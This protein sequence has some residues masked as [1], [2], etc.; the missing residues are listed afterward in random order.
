MFGG[1]FYS[2]SYA[3]RFL[4]K[5]QQRFP[6]DELDG[7][8][9]AAIKLL[10]D[11]QNEHPTF[12]KQMPSG[13]WRYGPG[14]KDMDATITSCATLALLA[15]KQAGYEVPNET[16]ERATNY[17]KQMQAQ[18]GSFYYAGRV[19]FSK[20]SV[21]RSAAVMDVLLRTDTID[22]EA[23]R[24]GMKYLKE[25]APPETDYFF[26]AHYYLSETLVF[27]P[28]EFA[29]WYDKAKTELL[30]RQQGDG[31]WN[32]PYGSEYATAKACIVLLSPVRENQKFAAADTGEPSL[33]VRVV[34]KAGKPIRNAEV[35]LYDEQKLNS[36]GEARFKNVLK[37][38]N[39][40]GEC[41][42][43]E[44]PLH[45]VAILVRGRKGK[46]DESSVH[47][48]T[49]DPRP[50]I[51]PNRLV[52]LEKDRNEI[53]VT[54]TMRQGV[55][56]QF[57]VVDAVTKRPIHF[58][59]IHWKDVKA[60]RWWQIGLLDSG[61]QHNATTLVPEMGSSVFRAARAGY[62]PVDFGFGGPLAVGVSTNRRI[63]LKPHPKVKL[64][65]VTPNGR[66]AVNAKIRWSNLHGLVNEETL[67]TTA[68]ANGTLEVRYPP[69]P[70]AAQLAVTHESGSLEIAFS[71]I[72][73]DGIL[74]LASADG[75]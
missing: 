31:D 64:S 23:R 27:D 50:R 47:L 35:L 57:E 52:R 15:A 14:L 62:V 11:S 9:N 8:I 73:D 54:H 10:A 37:R 56:L 26:Y 41:D 22:D 5:V 16:L 39:E 18:D 12:S 71:E 51:S 1:E 42:F 6:N 3:L 4:A 75:A 24:L 29:A 21:A 25:T 70:D 63:E 46:F 28:P 32:S 44:L 68:N 30:K 74:T 61:G 36:G 69:H 34:D 20:N 48:F 7:V 60:N 2:H 58:A 59:G 55:D 53:V 49:R 66:P 72:G 43:G 38:S 13:G 45:H 40:R 19:G 33:K 67:R 65:I 17:L